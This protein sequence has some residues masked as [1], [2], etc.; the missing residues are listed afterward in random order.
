MFSQAVAT[1]ISVIMRGCLAVTRLCKI[2]KNLMRFVCKSLP[3]VSSSN[4]ILDSCCKTNNCDDTVA[5]Q[6]RL[7]VRYHDTC[8]FV[9]KQIEGMQTVL[10]EL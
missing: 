9:Q 7:P 10:R 2:L 6:G 8:G 4:H 3:S 1:S 5:I